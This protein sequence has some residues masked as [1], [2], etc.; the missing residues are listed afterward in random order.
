MGERERR[1]DG[2]GQ[3]IR[4]EA[5]HSGEVKETS[6]NV[7]IEETR[8]RERDKNVKSHGEEGSGEGLRLL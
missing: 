5:E 4:T 3:K 1:G 7:R 6:R 2:W 8:E